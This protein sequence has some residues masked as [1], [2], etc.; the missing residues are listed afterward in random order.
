MSMSPATF[1]LLA[2]HFPAY[3]LHIPCNLKYIKWGSLFVDVSAVWGR[4]ICLMFTGLVICIKFWHDLCIVTVTVDCSK[5][6]L[7]VN[8]RKGT[9]EGRRRQTLCD[10]RHNNSIWKYFPPNFTFPL[11]D[12][13]VKDQ[14]AV[15]LIE[16]HN[17]H[18]GNRPVTFVTHEC[19]TIFFF[20]PS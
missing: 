19:F 4:S 10:K 17:K 2:V 1:I 7:I 20:V 16:L 11:K 14:N 15:I 6:L 8:L 12:L 13:F 9:A 3:L 18:A 5:T